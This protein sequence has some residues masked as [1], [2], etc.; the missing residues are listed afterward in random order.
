MDWT[1]HDALTAYV[2]ILKSDA[3]EQFRQEMTVWSTLGPHQAKN[4]KL[5]PPPAIPAILTS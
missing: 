3:R 2:E 1:I 5:P 4:G